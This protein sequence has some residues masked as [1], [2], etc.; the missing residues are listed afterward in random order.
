MREYFLHWTIL[1]LLLLFKA[2]TSQAADTFILDPNHSYVLWHISH[3]GF[4]HPSGK[5]FASGTLVLD[6]DHPN[7]DKVNV[8]IDVA[9]FVTGIKELDDHLRGASFFDTTQYPKA[10]FVSDKVNVTGSD[11]ANVHG[12]L[13]VR[14][15]SK[16]ITLTVK[17]NQYAMNIIN[18]KMTIG[19][20][21]MAHLKRSDFGI[22]AL[23]PGL[24]DD[25]TL[26]IEV[27]AA[28]K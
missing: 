24:G 20:S 7:E 19:F 13:T 8:T 18:N 6:K 11:T 14:G 28:K 26:N 3:F 1:F 4:S 25:V 12:I 27:E 9:N 16:P 10:T 23:L 15:I 22:T 2:T 17:F 5:W 21:A